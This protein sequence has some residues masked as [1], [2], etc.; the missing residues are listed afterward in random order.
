MV[1]L[2]ARPCSLC[3]NVIK[4]KYDTNSKTI[5]DIQGGRG[6]AIGKYRAGTG[7]KLSNKLIMC[8]SGMCYAVMIVSRMPEMKM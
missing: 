5:L 1:K 8:Q 4:V 3:G 2:L 7:Y 6:L